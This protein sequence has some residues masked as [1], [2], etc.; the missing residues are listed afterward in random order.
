MPTAADNLRERLEVGIFLAL[1]EEVVG[2]VL[3]RV[4]ILHHETAEGT[5]HIAGHV[6]SKATWTSPGTKAPKTWLLAR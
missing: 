4:P 3:L 1:D 5:L 2:K 6:P